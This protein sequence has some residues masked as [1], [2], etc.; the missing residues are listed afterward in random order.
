METFI[1]KDSASHP[2]GSAILAGLVEDDNDD[3]PLNKQLRVCC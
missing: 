2:A 1:P 3:V